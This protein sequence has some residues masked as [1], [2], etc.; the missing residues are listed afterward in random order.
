MKKKKENL[1]G[2]FGRFYNVFF[3]SWV[4]DVEK[5][6]REGAVSVKAKGWRL[7]IPLERVEV[8]RDR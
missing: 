3:L 5:D 7:V 2:K 6:G 4:L 8:T 1:G